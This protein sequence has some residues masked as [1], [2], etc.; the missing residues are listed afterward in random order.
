MADLTLE[1]VAQ[2]LADLQTSHDALTKTVTEVQASNDSLTKTVTD[3]NATIDSLQSAN[4]ALTKTVQT[5]QGVKPAAPKKED[6]FKPQAADNL[7]KS[8]NPANE[9]HFIDP[10]DGKTKYKFLFGH[11]TP[12]VVA[13]QPPQPKVTAKVA[14]GDKTL[15]A[16]LIKEG[17]GQ[18]KKV[19]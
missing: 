4:D 6:A 11:V 14:Q 13:G 15:Q 1:A 19:F 10:T 7:D 16:A 5:I 3:Q 9:Y 17:S 12:P 18:I 8:G 2:Q